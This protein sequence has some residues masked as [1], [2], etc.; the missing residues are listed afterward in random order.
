MLLALQD[1][2]ARSRLEEE[3]RAQ[4]AGALEARDRLR[5]VI[6][7]IS[8]ELRTPLTSVLGFARLLQDR[9][10]AEPEKRQGWAGQVIEKARLMARLVDEVSELARL[11]S[12]EFSLDRRPT[13]L[14]ALARDTAESLGDAL[15]RHTVEL[16]VQPPGKRVVL[17]M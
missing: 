13:D 10:D 1:V 11:G 6:E 4:T 9:P 15:G 3:L 8:H 12:T 7:V 2:S 16:E 17:Y 14:E 5:A